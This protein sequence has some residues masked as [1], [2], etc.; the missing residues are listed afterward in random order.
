MMGKISM[1]KVSEIF[2][3]RF[4]LN[5]SYRVI[6]ESLG[7]S[8]STISDYIR[9]AKAAGIQWPLPEELSEQ[10]LYDKLFLPAR[11]KAKKRIVPNWQDIHK[12]LRKKGVTLQLLWR[13]YR[14]HHPNGLGYSQFCRH[15]RGFVKT[16]SPVMRQ[17]HKGGEKSFVDYAGMTVDWIDY[18]SGEVFTAQIFVGCLG[19]SQLL[20]AEATATQQL[21]D[22]INSHIHMFEY[23]GGVTEIVVPDNLRSGVTKSHRYDPDIN[24]NYQHFSEHYGVAIVLARAASPRDKAK[25][26]NGVSIIERQILAPL[27]N[28]TFTSLGEINSAIK[29]RLSVLNNQRFQKM[30][31]TRKELFEQLD[32]P[33]LKP[34]PATSYQYATWKKAKINI[35]YHFVFEDCYYSVPYQH[36]GKK[37]EIRATNKSVE[38]FNDNQRIATHH[39]CHKKYSF[40]TIAEH[41]PKNHQEHA[42]FSPERLQNWASKIGMHTLTF[43]NNMMASRAFPQQAY[44]SCLGLLRLSN[45]YG[46]PRLDKACEKAL[47]VGAT[48][49]QHVEAILKNNLE[50][51]K[52][53]DVNS[54]APVIAHA[55]IRGSNYYQ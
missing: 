1:R 17:K 22:W 9:R 8:I 32:K 14:E 18:A 24:A 46:E 6:A 33:A 47:L 37:V 15:Y 52:E 10:A 49:Y 50:E 11:I 12:E 39:R 40:I 48:R 43:I 23:F 53:N 27:R 19:A 21:P 44:R 35:D 31:I 41:M 25:V 7:L 29:E 28:V 16:V 55:N 5:L 30:E 3:Q 38:C 4:E 51:T 34:L 2:R 36:I 26:E 54:D 13:E 45:Y 20:F 42:K